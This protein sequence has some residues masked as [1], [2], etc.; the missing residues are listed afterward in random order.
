MANLDCN[1]RLKLKLKTGWLLSFVILIYCLPAE[2]LGR[3]FGDFV[4]LVTM[5]QVVI[6][7][8][9]AYTSKDIKLSS[10]QLLILTFPTVLLFLTLTSLTLSSSSLIVSDTFEI[11]KPILMI[12]AVIASCSFSWNDS[13]LK[14][15]LVWPLTAVVLVSFC[16]YWAELFLGGIGKEISLLYKRDSGILNFKAVGSFSTTYIAGTFFSLTSLMF[17]NIFS[18]SKGI[19]KI[20][21][22]F[23]FFVFLLSVFLVLGSQSRTSFIALG[24]S[25]FL[26]C[27]FLSIYSRT[28]R[29]YFLLSLLLLFVLAFSFWSVL[30]DNVQQKYPYL[31]SGITSYLLNYESHLAGRN[32][33][34]VRLDQIFLAYERNDF[35]IVGKGINKSEM[36][37]L[38]SWYALY[39]YRYGL[40]GMLA[41]MT[42]WGTV[43]VSAV[44]VA[45]SKFQSVTARSLALSVFS[46]SMLLP[47]FGLSSVITDFP[48][49]VGFYYLLAG[50][51]FNLSF[52][53][54]SG[55]FYRE[56]N[57]ST[58]I[59]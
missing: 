10:N 44:K 23:Y 24:I 52:K 42:F 13:N 33:L 19:G 37:L 4:N 7:L 9:L 47:V 28:F 40:V 43:I 32:S 30:I 35:I 27:I 2:F 11:L 56:S 53:N 55:N 18:L 25:I 49:L 12:L 5:F 17:L 34:T 16:I 45:N 51:V 39:Y 1:N 22:I 29:R 41:Y 31:Y 58:P 59:L 15:F 38:E 3:F 14:R 48:L 8:V 46:F 21:R 20:K 36:R 6:F 57:L 26:N 50:V 54:P